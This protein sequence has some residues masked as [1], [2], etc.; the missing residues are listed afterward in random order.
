MIH[1]LVSTTFVIEKCL[2]LKYDELEEI[3]V[4]CQPE[5]VRLMDQTELHVQQDMSNF[6]CSIKIE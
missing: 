2:N 1:Q 6:F 4:K 5:L 3:N